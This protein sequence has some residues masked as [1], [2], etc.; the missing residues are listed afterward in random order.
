M[1]TE[2]TPARPVRLLACDLDGTLL[3]PGGLG[4]EIARS[5]VERCRSRGV[6]FTLATGRVFGAVEKYLDPGEGGFALKDPI[7]TNGG[8]M[9]AWPDGRPIYERTIEAGVA[10]VVASGLRDLNLPFYFIAGRSMFTEWAG[11]ETETY[12][13]SLGFGIDLVPSLDGLGLAPTQIA[14]RVP[15]ADA[16]RFVERFRSAWP[17]VTVLLSLP[18][19]IEVQADGVSKSSALEYLA[20]YLGI[21]REDVLAVGDSLNDLDMLAWAGQ[22]ACVGNAHPEVMG[23][24]QAVA[25]GFYSEGVMEIAQKFIV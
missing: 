1:R 23:R 15:P 14:V 24:V 6:A 11:P 17:G 3:G 9:V 19:L 2:R 21:S 12:S 16:G 10:R 20:R 25:Q 8:A 5:V 4:L 13:N 18:H 7:V 22:S